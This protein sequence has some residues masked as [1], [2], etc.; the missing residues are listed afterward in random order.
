MIT[1]GRGVLRLS[2]GLSFIGFAS[3]HYSLQVASKLTV[4]DIGEHGRWS[5][6]SHAS[7]KVT[8]SFT[9]AIIRGK[10]VFPGKLSKS[11]SQKREVRTQNSS[12]ATCKW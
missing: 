8:Q 9:D 1:D 11:S 6:D 5:N 10:S 4:S 2:A 3:F 7:T 12:Q